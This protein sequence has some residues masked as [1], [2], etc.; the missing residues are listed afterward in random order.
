V[1]CL[2]SNQG[3]A[4]FQRLARYR[5]PRCAWVVNDGVRNT[6]PPTCCRGDVS[7]RDNTPPRKLVP[8]RAPSPMSL[9]MELRSQDG[10]NGN[11]HPPLRQQ[12]APTPLYPTARRAIALEELPVGCTRLNSNIRVGAKWL[13]R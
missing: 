3:S 7:D 8:C 1:L 10:V 9:H 11:P 4:D 5:A 13:E 6:V 2:L 12:Y